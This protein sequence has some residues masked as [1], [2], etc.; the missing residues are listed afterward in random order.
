MRAQGYKMIRKSRKRKELLDFMLNNLIP[1]YIDYAA[2]DDIENFVNNEKEDL[3][4]YGAFCEYFGLGRW[5]ESMMEACEF[6]LS[7][8]FDEYAKEIEWRAQE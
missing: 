3:G 1:D 7:E 2:L 6:D 4:E 5:F 8:F